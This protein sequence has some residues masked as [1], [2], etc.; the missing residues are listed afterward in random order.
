MGRRHWSFVSDEIR[1]NV[2]NTELFCENKR[3]CQNTEEL[4]FKLRVK[5]QF[6]SLV[7]SSGQMQRVDGFVD[8]D[9]TITT[10]TYTLLKDRCR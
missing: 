2:A 4:T 10:S 7:I 9:S 3:K 5:D 1:F 6:A 8:F